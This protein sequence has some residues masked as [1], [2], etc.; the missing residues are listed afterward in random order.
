MGSTYSLR[1]HWYSRWHG[2]PL[3]GTIRYDQ[4]LP[5]SQASSLL[6]LRQISAF[7]DGQSLLM[8]PASPHPRHSISV[9]G[10]VHSL[11]MCSS[12]PHCKPV[13]SHNLHVTNGLQHLRSGSPCWKTFVPACSHE[14]DGRL[15]YNLH[16]RCQSWKSAPASL[17]DNYSSCGQARHTVKAIKSV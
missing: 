13:S 1:A 2:V 14:H 7:L 8:C 10:S 17:Q 5:L 4:Q 12:D 15:R 11:A 9:R 6:T 3:L 16:T